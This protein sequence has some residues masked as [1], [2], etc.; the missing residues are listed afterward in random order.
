MVVVV[1]IVVICVCAAT[2]VSTVLTLMDSLRLLKRARGSGVSKKKH[3]LKQQ[4]GQRAPP[5]YSNNPALIVAV[6]VG[7][8]I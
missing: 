1:A 6:V 5:I 2:G 8:R 7:S 3:S 4:Q